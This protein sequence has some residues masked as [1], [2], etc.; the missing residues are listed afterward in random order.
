M[1]PASRQYLPPEVLARIDRLDLRARAVVEGVLTGMHKSP[2]KGNSVE[3]LQ[4]REYTR[5]DDLRRVDWKVWGRQDRFYVKEYEN[6]TNLRLFLLVDGSASMDYIP[7]RFDQTKG[8][9]KY[10]YAA[11]L[12]TSLA[13]LGLSQGDAVG[14][15]V[16]DEQVRTSVPARTNRSHLSSL[17]A[18][19]ERP[20]QKHCSDFHAVLRNL[21]ENLPRRGL[22]IIFSDLFGERDALYK[23]LQVLR[24]RGHDVAICHILDDDELDFPFD[25]PTRFEGLELGGEIS[26][27]P[28]ALRDGY[29]QAMEQF[30]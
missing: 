4:H 26:C 18:E 2:Y 6:E 22:V 8:L 13:W 17:I 27:N 12:A 20:R 3:F 7:P 30:L 24:Q 19:L 25:G 9:T 1:T 11:T 28:R 14:A 10:D 15:S 29:L 16:F 23:G 5:G 21:A